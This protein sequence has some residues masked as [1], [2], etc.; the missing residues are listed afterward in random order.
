VEEGSRA[1]FT[2]TT[3]LPREVADKRSIFVDD[4]DYDD[5]TEAEIKIKEFFGSCGAIKRVT[6][7][8]QRSMGG[9]HAFV[10]FTTQ[11]AIAEALKLDKGTG[12]M[13]LDKKC[14]ND[15]PATVRV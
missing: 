6:I 15:K 2:H 3:Y 5:P 9:R 8:T 7:R 11:E 4:L 14:L 13:K 10:E 12:D 1:D